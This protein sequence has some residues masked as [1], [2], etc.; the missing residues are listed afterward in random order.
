MLE[1]PAAIET[2]GKPRPP[3]AEAI[4]R[5]IAQIRET[6]RSDFEKAQSPWRKAELAKELISHVEGVRNSPDKLY[7]MLHLARRLAIE[8][9]AA[10]VACRSIDEWEPGSRSIAVGQDGRTDGGGG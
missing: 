1:P 7:A 5:G 9:G 10:D 3:A 2:Q 6:Y 4:N 8:G